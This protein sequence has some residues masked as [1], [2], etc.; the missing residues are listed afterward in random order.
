LIRQH[1]SE[2]SRRGKRR[3]KKLKKREVK[4]WLSGR[5]SRRSA[6]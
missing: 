1:N 4:H 3:G 6:K 2:R 5:R